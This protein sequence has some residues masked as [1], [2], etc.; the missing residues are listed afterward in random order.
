VL[1]KINVQSIL[2]GDD[3]S[4]E[5]KRVLQSLSHYS[6]RQKLVYKCLSY[7]RKIIIQNEKYKTKTCPMCGEYN[8]WVTKEKKI[9]CKGC[10]KTYDRDGG[11]SQNIYMLA[12]E[13]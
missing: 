5:I 6:F 8:E 2:M 9:K 13:E 1:G 7:D 10:D 3:I 12:L 4:S 11:A